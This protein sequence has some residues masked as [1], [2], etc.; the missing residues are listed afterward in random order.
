[1]K[2]IIYSNGN[3]ECER[4]EALLEAVHQDTIVYKLGQDFT[5]T[6]FRDEFGD[7]AEYP[8]IALGMHYRG[9]LKETLHYMGEKGMLLV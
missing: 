9:T 5:E 1:M 4:S 8:M 3:Q 2:A 6:Q 7:E